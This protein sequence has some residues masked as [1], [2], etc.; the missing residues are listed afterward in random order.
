MTE[1]IKRLKLEAFTVTASIGNEVTLK[2]FIYTINKLQDIKYI[3]LYCFSSAGCCDQA[4]YNQSIAKEKF[5]I[6]CFSL[7]S[8]MNT[9]LTLKPIL[10]LAYLRKIISD[11]KLFQ[12]Q[13]YNAKACFLSHFMEAGWNKTHIEAF[14]LFFINFDS[15]LF[16]DIP[17]SK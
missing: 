2:L 10:A 5:G 1:A 12:K 9:F 7:N 11:G 17:K 16:N 4:D 8:L 3:E 13:V 15:H 6:A 14:G